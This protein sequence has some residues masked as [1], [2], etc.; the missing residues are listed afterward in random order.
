MPRHHGGR[1]MLV[2]LK[3][4]DVCYPSIELTGPSKQA[5][6]KICRSHSGV[7]NLHSRSHIGRIR[8]R[9]FASLPHEDSLGVWWTDTGSRGARAE[10]RERRRLDLPN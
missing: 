1:P 7:R 6:L 10:M 8:T 9:S 5:T 4:R 2:R 3:V